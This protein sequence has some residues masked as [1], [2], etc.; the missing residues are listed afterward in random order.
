M[1][2]RPSIGAERRRSGFVLVLSG[3]GA[4]GFAHAGVLRALEH[5]GLAPSAIVGVSMG[6]VVGAAYALRHDWYHAVLTMDTASFPGPPPGPEMVRPGVVNRVRRGWSI[7]R[8]A[9]RMLRTWGP[10]TS[11]TPAARRVL[12]TL[13]GSGDLASGRV[14][15]LVSCSDLWSG[16][17]V[18]LRSGRAVDAIYASAA[19]AGVLPPAR[20]GGH[21]LADGAYTDIAPIDLARTL[22]GPVVAVDVGQLSGQPR[23]R[24]GLQALMRAMEI[25][26]SRHAELRFSQADLVIRPVFRR[27]V[28]TLE[29]S[30]AR[31]CAAAG[32]RAARRARASLEALLAGAERVPLRAEQ[33]LAGAAR[34]Q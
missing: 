26:H 15:V 13:L 2:D 17:R 30:A 11:A 34:E 33:R 7:A 18:V 4:R 32:A 21:L 28:D 25:C 5:R 24:N 3:G 1:S 20:H 23:I 14:P 29:F 31:E 27:P 8:A 12:A 16:K 22:G 9:E 19:L 6:A 10:G